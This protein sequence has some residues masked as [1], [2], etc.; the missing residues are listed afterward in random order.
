[1]RIQLYGKTHF[2]PVKREFLY[3]QT[4]NVGTFHNNMDW[5]IVNPMWIGTIFQPQYGL[6]FREMGV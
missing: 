5:I 6:D 3:L 4:H 1:M 2:F